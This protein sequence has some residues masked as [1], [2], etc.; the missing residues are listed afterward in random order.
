MSTQEKRTATGTASATISIDENDFVADRFQISE[1]EDETLFAA[2]HK[3][4]SNVIGVYL[5]AGL[6]PGIYDIGEN[7]KVR[8]FYYHRFSDYPMQ[9]VAKTGKFEI[10]SFDLGAQKLE[11]KFAFVTSGQKPGDTDVDVTEGVLDCH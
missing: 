8:A 2:L 7:E 4:S 3:T 11:A 6:T 5:T 9:L 1:H 10:I